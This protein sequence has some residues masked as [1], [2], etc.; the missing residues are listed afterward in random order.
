MSKRLVWI[1]LVLSLA[2][3][4]SFA[5]GFLYARKA[6]R[7]RATPEGRA[8]WAGKQL[9]LDASQ[10]TSF[11]AIHQEWL[12]EMR[13][14]Q[15]S[16]RADQDAFWAAM[17]RDEDPQKITASLE[18]LFSL[19]TT[20]TVESMEYLRRTMKLLTPPQRQALVEMIR[21]RRRL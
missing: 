7:D 15:Q 18:R 4:A 8:R 6:L 3:N 16:T 21:S 14:F 12:Q 11:E 1:F 9:K 2:L 20:A 17:L 5:V 10:R 19:Q 13:Q